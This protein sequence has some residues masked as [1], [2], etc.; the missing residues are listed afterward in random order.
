[1]SFGDVIGFALFMAG[2]VAVAG[3]LAGAYKRRLGFLERRMEIEAAQ[4]AAT[5]ALHGDAELENRVR[6]LER[7]ITDGADSRD[8]AFQIEALRDGTRAEVTTQ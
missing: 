4:L 8:I 6:V 2:M 7:I 3:I 1:M 5:P